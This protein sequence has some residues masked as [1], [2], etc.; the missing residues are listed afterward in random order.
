MAKGQE[1][2]F[3]TPATAYGEEEKMRGRGRSMHR[4]KKSSKRTRR[5]GGRRK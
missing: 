1:P 5:R 4:T 2:S 3:E